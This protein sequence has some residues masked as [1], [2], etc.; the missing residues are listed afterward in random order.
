MVEAAGVDLHPLFD[1]TQLADFSVSPEVIEGGKQVKF[2][3]GAYV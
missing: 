2:T 3:E 1:N